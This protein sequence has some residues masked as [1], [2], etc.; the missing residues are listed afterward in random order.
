VNTLLGYVFAAIRGH[1]AFALELAIRAR[2]RF[3]D[4]RFDVLKSAARRRIRSRLVKLPY[5]AARE[6]VRLRT[7]S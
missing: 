5:S 7:G 2:K 6:L 4:P 1:D 3:G